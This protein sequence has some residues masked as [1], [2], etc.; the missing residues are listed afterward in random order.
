MEQVMKRTNGIRNLTGGGMRTHHCWMPLAVA[1]TVM[2]RLT[3]P[4]QEWETVDD[5]APAVGNAEAH[6][7]AADA[8]G[9]IYVVG[10]AN[11]HGIVRYSADDGLNWITRDDCV[12]LSEANTFFN[13][14]TIDSRGTVFVGGAATAAGWRVVHWLV[15]RSTDQG[16]T[17]ETVED[18][19]VPRSGPEQEGI[20]GVVYS[21]ASD[22]QGRVYGGGVMVPGGPSYP[23]WWIRG[24]GIGG[25]N[26]DT[27]LVAFGGYTEFFK[28]TC[29]SEDVYA[30]GSTDGDEYPF[31]I[32]RILKTSDHGVTWTTSF[33]GIGD[34][35]SAIAANSAGYLYSAG[36]RWNNSTSV[37]WQVRQ[38]A[39]GGTNW[40]ILDSSVYEGDPRVGV[41]QPCANS[42]AVDNAGNVCATG[43]FID[44]WAKPIPN[45]TM[46][47]T[48]TSWFTRQYLTADGQWRTTDLFSYS[49]NRHGAAMGAAIAHSGSAFMAGYCTSDSG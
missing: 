13:A 43:A 21:L 41:D 44:F 36:V 42:I 15:R 16:V 5:F 39:P 26:W 14:V 45:G 22:G 40:T 46:Y 6:S 19:Y 3:A 7:V 49:T 4:A 8:A 18:F 24:S 20:N 12:Y 48:D 30:T 1:A 31:G 28:I 23:S 25:A 9:G 10:T 33:E 27:K 32:G 35:P 17:W 11:G 38:T 29:A 47:G 2:G 37:V 34:Y